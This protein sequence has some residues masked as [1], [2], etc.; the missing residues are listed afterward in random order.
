M[1]TWKDRIGSIIDLIATVEGTDFGAGR[2][3]LVEKLG[4]SMSIMYKWLAGNKP[5]TRFKNKLVV[6]EDEYRGKL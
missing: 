2:A 5:H 6:I 3:R 1:S 4:C